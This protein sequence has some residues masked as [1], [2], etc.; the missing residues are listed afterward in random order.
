LPNCARCAKL[1][2][3]LKVIVHIGWRKT[4]SSAIQYLLDVNR[5][6][7]RAKYAIDYPEAGLF[8]RAHHLVGWDLLGGRPRR[9]IEPGERRL[10]EGD[11]PG[12]LREAKRLGC[13]RMAVSSEVFSNDNP[14]LP[15]RIREQLHGHT[16]EI[17]AY[18]RRQ[19]RYIEARYNQC[20]K[21]GRPVGE[22]EPY[23]AIQL[24]SLDY[25]EHFRRWSAAFGRENLKVRVYDPSEFQNGDVR[26]DFLHAAGIAPDGLT[27]EEGARNASLTFSGVQFLRRFESA[28]PAGRERRRVVRLLQLYARER[29]DHGSLLLPP[30]RRAILE[31]FRES[32]RRF[33]R[34]FLDREN[35]FELSDGE[36]AREEAL[37]RSFGE[38]RFREMLR[39]VQARLEAAHTAH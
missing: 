18:V 15:R 16:V 20:V 36:L 6:A 26:I 13:T 11:F 39:F 3:A 27:F 19:D 22:L 12:M 17:V 38:E 5:D 23:I 28:P 7:L 37:D 29:A 25:H 32:N 21:D 1:P 33:A 35:V 8:G 34:E 4:G 24:P 14:D 9:A 2:T 10:R 31:R 30:Q